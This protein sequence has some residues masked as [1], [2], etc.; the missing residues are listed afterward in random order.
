MSG[1]GG[2]GGTPN[3]PK[4]PCDE[5]EFETHLS[6]PKPAALKGVAVGE[7]L[8]VV[9]DKSGKV[10]HVVVVRKGAV[11]GGLASQKALE[12]RDCLE[13]GHKYQAEVAAIAGGHI[14]VTV[15]SA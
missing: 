4:T 1:S 9:L 7:I 13:D 6:S 10:S 2:G 12:L 15:T 11:A 3:T 5:I 8:Q 14:S